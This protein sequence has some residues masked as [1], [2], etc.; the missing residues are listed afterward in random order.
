MRFLQAADHTCSWHN[1]V[2]ACWQRRSRM[3]HGLM[4]HGNAVCS[5]NHSVTRCQAQ[6]AFAV[7]EHTASEHSQKDSNQAQDWSF[8]A[9][10]AKTRRLSNK[11]GML[12]T[13]ISLFCP[14]CN[15]LINIWM[16]RLCRLYDH[17]TI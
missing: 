10:T 5:E 3:L 14:L 6:G 13:T 12:V 4:E 16:C 17:I 11:V 8:V 7:L 2:L 9:A 1:L 15:P